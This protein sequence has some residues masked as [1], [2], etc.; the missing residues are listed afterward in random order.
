[1]LLKPAE[2]YGIQPI[3]DAISDNDFEYDFNIGNLIPYHC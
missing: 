3:S 1:M 2:I